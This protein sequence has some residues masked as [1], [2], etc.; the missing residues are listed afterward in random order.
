MQ[1]LNDNRRARHDFEIL[2]RIEAGIALTGTEVKSCRARNV[3]LQESYVRPEDGE[4]ILVGAHIA[5]YTHGNRL[6]HKPT[7]ER[8]L[9]LHRREI[10]KLAQGVQTEG[11][12]LI[13]LRIYLTERGRIKLE[14]GL[15]RGRKLHDKREVMRRKV[16]Q[17]EVARAVQA[18]RR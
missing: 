2:D 18:H 15:C 1:V 4:L 14:I 5:E 6:N 9:L 16:H 8:K 12:T 7:R 10:R 13:P 17:Q 3:S 11:L